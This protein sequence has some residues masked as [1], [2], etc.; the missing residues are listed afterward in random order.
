MERYHPRYLAIFFTFLSGVAA[1]SGCGDDTGQDAEVRRLRKEN[2]DLQSR[3]AE[4]E[5]T[6]IEGSELKLRISQLQQ[7]NDDLKSTAN[8]GERIEIAINRNNQL[9]FHISFLM[10]IILLLVIVFLQLRYRRFYDECNHYINVRLH[11]E[12]QGGKDGR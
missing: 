5:A 11:D 10:N 2:R 7:E 4:L 9:Y 1:L 3:V 12:S 8:L 6:S